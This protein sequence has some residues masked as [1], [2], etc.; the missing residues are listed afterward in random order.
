MNFLAHMFLSFNDQDLLVGQFI[1]DEVK[2]SR[3]DAISQGWIK[4]ILLHRH[5]DDYTDHHPV[6]TALRAQLRPYLG[7]LS[8]V[9]IDVWYDHMLARE[10]ARYH[11]M[12]LEDFVQQSLTILDGMSN[13]LPEKSAHRLKLMI[14]HNWLMQYATVHGI[15]TTFLM[16][17]RRFP[18]ASNLSKAPDI[19]PLMQKNIEES[20][21]AFIPDLI[22]AAEKK[23]AYGNSD[24]QK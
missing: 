21:F 13:D 9:A 2:G 15:H 14:E 23:I 5:I 3:F 7:L 6:N 1:A 18:F 16:M 20:F 12:P 17:S 10:W 22:S 24:G 11:P 4:G 19:W 8:P